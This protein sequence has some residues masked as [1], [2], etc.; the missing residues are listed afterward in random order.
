MSE[1][2]IFAC[3][4][5]DCTFWVQAGDGVECPNCGSTERVTT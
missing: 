4:V 3:V 5:C 2:H 1:W